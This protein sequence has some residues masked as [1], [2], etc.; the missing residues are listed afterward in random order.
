MSDHELATYYLSKGDYQK[1]YDHTKRHHDAAPTPE[2]AQKLSRATKM[3]SAF[4]DLQTFLKIPKD[5]YYRVLSVN[6]DDSVQVVEQRY[7]RLM[8]KFHPNVNYVPECNEAAKRIQIAYHTIKDPVKRKE[9][10]SASERASSEYEDFYEV[11]RRRIEREGDVYFRDFAN[12]FV[13][14]EFYQP[15]IRRRREEISFGGLVAII[16][17]VLLLVSL[18]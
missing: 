10:D 2:S 8:I 12:G 16:L 6:K 5:D 18:G 17:F 9:Y 11:L 14:R 3:L 15:R 13:Y 4:N 1:H 7:K